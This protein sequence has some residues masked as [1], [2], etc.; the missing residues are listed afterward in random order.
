LQSIGSS[1]LGTATNVESGGLAGVLG[2]TR[3]TGGTPTGRLPT[4]FVPAGSTSVIWGTPATAIPTSGSANYDLVGQTAAASDD[5]S[6]AAGVLRSGA[7]RVNF[8]DLKVG[9]E[10]VVG[11]AGTDYSLASVGGIAAPSFVLGAN[12]TFGRSF[13]TNGSAS[14]T[15]S[16]N[17]CTSVSCEASIN[18]FLAGPGASHAGVSYS[19]NTAPTPAGSVVRGGP[20]ISGVAAFTR[21]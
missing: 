20:S 4:A 18:G 10:L 8:S 7:M 6:I 19:F 11:V 9:V 17:G 3:W 5:G 14:M 15:I 12:G 21:R 13:S 2:W 1:G 16:G